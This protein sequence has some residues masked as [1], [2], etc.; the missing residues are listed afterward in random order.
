MQTTNVQ[1]AHSLN[2][3]STFVV[4]CLDSIIPLLAIAKISSQEERMMELKADILIGYI[5]L[6]AT[7][8]TKRILGMIFSNFD[9]LNNHLTYCC[10]LQNFSHFILLENLK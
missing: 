2:L 8:V 10:S 4:R 5:P 3:I 7:E 6:Y 9:F 1:P